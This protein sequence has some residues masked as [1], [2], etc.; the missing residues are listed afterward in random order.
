MQQQSNFLLV[1]EIN[2]PGQ[3]VDLLPLLIRGHENSKNLRTASEFIRTATVFPGR[4]ILPLGSKMSLPTEFKSHWQYTKFFWV[5]GTRWKNSLDIVRRSISTFFSCF[6]DPC[7]PDSEE[8]GPQSGNWFETYA[9]SCRIAPQSHCTG[10]L[11]AGAATD[12]LAHHSTFLSFPP[13]PCLGVNPG[14]HLY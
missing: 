2:H 14:P 13:P 1:I 7:V 8:I 6:L 9:V 5:M 11:P 12:L 10:G 4:N 3:N